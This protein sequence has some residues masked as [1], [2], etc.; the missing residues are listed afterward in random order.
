MVPKND[1]WGVEEVDQSVSI[2]LHC[3]KMMLGG[4]KGSKNND[5][6]GGFLPMLHSDP[7]S[8]SKME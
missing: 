8:G 5:G 4:R 2:H 7:P 3:E 6:G 1:D